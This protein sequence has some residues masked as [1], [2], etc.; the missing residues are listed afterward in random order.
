MST[1]VVLFH[2]EE[3]ILPDLSDEEL[4]EVRDGFLEEL[5]KYPPGIRVDTYVNENG[6]GLCDW[7]VPDKIDNP[8]ETVEEIVE[9]VLGE[10]PADPVVAVN[11]VL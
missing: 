9:S 4:K 6:V 11:K 10:P 1:K 5:K 3:N 2:V 8:V 7:E